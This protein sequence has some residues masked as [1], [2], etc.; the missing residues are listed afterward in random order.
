MSLIETAVASNWFSQ[1]WY[2]DSTVCV[3]NQIFPALI[4]D[5]DTRIV[6]ASVLSIREAPCIYVYTQRTPIDTARE[7]VSRGG[8]VR[9]ARRIRVNSIYFWQLGSAPICRWSSL[10]RSYR[11]GNSIPPANP[12]LPS[13]LRRRFDSPPGLRDS[14]WLNTHENSRNRSR[15]ATALWLIRFF[16]P[17]L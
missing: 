13:F 6:F 8:F 17:L 14:I 16:V 7:N 12:A 1:W 4:R 5:T 2:V 3:A 11:C 15:N 9:S 10:V